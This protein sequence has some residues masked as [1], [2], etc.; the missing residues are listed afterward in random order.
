MSRRRERGRVGG[1]AGTLNLT[2]MIDV[3]FQLL[4]YFVLGLSLEM[5]EELIRTEL[6]RR[7]AG[8]VTLAVPL[9]AEVGAG[10]NWEQAH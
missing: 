5:D 1:G 2:P 6:P 3:V 4:I 10:P 9:L 8:V 7:M